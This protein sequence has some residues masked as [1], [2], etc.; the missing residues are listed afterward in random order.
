MVFNV[1]CPPNFSRFFLPSYMEKLM[2]HPLA[3]VGCRMLRGAEQ[4]MLSAEEGSKR[5]LLAEVGCQMLKRAE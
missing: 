3:G 5:I 4:R 1:S 2:K